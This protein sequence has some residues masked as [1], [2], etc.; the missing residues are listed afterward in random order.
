[1]RRSEN[2][3]Y[4]I[5]WIITDQEI[6]KGEVKLQRKLYLKLIESSVRP[7]PNL[8]ASS[9]NYYYYNMNVKMNVKYN[10]DLPWQVAKK[11][12]KNTFH[13]LSLS[14]SLPFSLSLA[15]TLVFFIFMS[16]FE[17]GLFICWTFLFNLF[18]MRNRFLKSQHFFCN[19]YLFTCMLTHRHLNNWTSVKHIFLP[20]MPLKSKDRL[21][22][23]GP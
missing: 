22:N 14:L 6:S 2:S 21:L 1:M 5:I 7:S 18:F 17:T 3:N 12:K 10:K 9:R 19:I 15:C 16:A 23:E 4:L 20:F 8:G 11:T 13:T